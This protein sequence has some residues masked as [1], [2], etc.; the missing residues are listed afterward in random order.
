M[1]SA[2]ACA[3]L[4]CPG[5][6][7][8]AFVCSSPS[9][10]HCCALD[11]ITLS[12]LLRGLNG[13]NAGVPMEAVCDVPVPSL[14]PGRP[15][16]HDLNTVLQIRPCCSSHTARYPPHTHSTGTMGSLEPQCAITDT[17]ERN[18]LN[19]SCF[20]PC[21]CLC[22]QYL[23]STAGAKGVWRRMKVNFP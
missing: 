11:D 8:Q 23:A 17:S 15:S 1:V 2:E 4:C 7:Q 21:C 22:V 20:L 18:F 6:P 3:S 13:L 14:S 9:V 19:F 16:V 5:P 10:R 12:C